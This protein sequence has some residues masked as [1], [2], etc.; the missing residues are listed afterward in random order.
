MIYLMNWDGIF[1]YTYYNKELW[2]YHCV[3]NNPK[4]EE[5]K[6]I[7]NNIFFKLFYLYTNNSLVFKNDHRN[8]TGHCFINKEEFND[9][10]ISVELH[11]FGDDDLL[12]KIEL[13]VANYECTFNENISGYK[14]LNFSVVCNDSNNAC[15]YLNDLCVN[16]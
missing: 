13:N 2:Y 11:I 8:L 4:K 16:N 15:V 9:E 1:L 12:K 7:N 3:D 5:E 10:N 6:Y 14:T